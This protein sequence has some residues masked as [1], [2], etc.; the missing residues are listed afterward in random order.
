MEYE[1][2]H[3]A[4]KKS[5]ESETRL[6]AKCTE[7][8]ADIV[9]NAAKVSSALKLSEDD[10]NTIAGLK[11][12]IE[13]AWKMVDASHEKEARAKDS[14]QGLK[15]EIANL[16]SVV[17]RGPDAMTAGMDQTVEELIAAKEALA[18]ERD[19]QVD[20]IVS[21]RNEVAE[22]S[23][24]LRTAESSKQGLEDE[25]GKLRDQVES[26]KLEGEREARKKERL[27]KELAELKTKLENKQHDIKAKTHTIKEAE[28]AAAKLE[29]MLKEQRG[30]TE[31][32]KKEYGALNEKL[33][34]LTTELE[35]QMRSNAQLVTENGTKRAELEAR[36]TELSGIKQD[37]LRAGK[38]R[39]A[40]VAKLQGVEKEKRE[41]ERDRDDLKRTIAELERQIEAERKQAETEV[42]KQHELKRERDILT[43]L[44][45]Q[46]ESATV[47]QR[48][49]VKVNENTRKTLEQEIQGYKMEAQKQAKMILLARE[50]EGEVRRRGV[51]RDGAVPRR[52]SR[53]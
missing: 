34:K 19:A 1:K 36:E 12:E 13:K 46:A 38:I 43:K 5:H 26:K 25:L 42:K 2:I 33:Q 48:D 35:E 10:Q 51:G 49:L 3:K 40:T 31:R 32:A 45:S 52:R 27:D 20:Q 22:M 8:N 15:L 23:E 14:I 50:A 7:L 28:E 37:A 29:G 9:N 16:G 44:K 30:A 53:R 4:L 6:L 11:A 18:A 47:E 21:L 39:D 17:E 41:T 24:R